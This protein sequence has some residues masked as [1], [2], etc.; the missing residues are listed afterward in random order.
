MSH[1]DKEMLK[2]LDRTIGGL[3]DG[4]ILD[5]DKP[6]EW[7]SLL[8]NRRKPWTYRAFKQVG[9]VRVCL[10][11]FAV[12]DDHEAFD[13]PH[14]WPGAFKIIKG[15][16]KMTVGFSQNRTTHPEHVLTTVLNRGSSYAITNPMTWHS[17]IPLE[18]C[19]TV[20]V[21]GTPWDAS[22]AHTNVRTT[23]GKDL[24]EMPPDELIK[25]LATFRTLL[26]TGGH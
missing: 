7:T 21:N 17:V 26:L 25:H 5:L 23:K 4:T 22:E 16:Y 2:T 8:I 1:T 24:D 18:E 10:H 6:Q 11:R 20:M 14:P 3:L 12:C 9:D 15:S 13:H 19:W